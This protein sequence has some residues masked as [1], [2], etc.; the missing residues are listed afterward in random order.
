MHTNHKYPH[1][2][3]TKSSSL[4]VRPPLSLFLLI[5]F[6]AR[7]LARS[8]KSADASIVHSNTQR[9]KRVCEAPH[10]QHHQSS[11]GRTYAA[12][13]LIDGLRMD[14][15]KGGRTLADDIEFQCC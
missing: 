11:D 5:K 10:L 7:L 4:C 2:L 15:T 1:H 9:P 12:G 3:S 13:P 8:L 6:T 14:M